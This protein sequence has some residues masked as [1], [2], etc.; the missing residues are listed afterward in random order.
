MSWRLSAWRRISA[1]D[2]ALRLSACRNESQGMQIAV[3]RL[4]ERGVFAPRP[5]V[6]SR[7]ELR[8]FSGQ[9]DILGEGL[10]G[11]D[12]QRRVEHRTI[13]SRGGK[14]HRSRLQAR[15]HVRSAR[16]R[17]DGAA[18]LGRDGSAVE[19]EHAAIRVFLDGPGN[20]AEELV[21]SDRLDIAVG[22]RGES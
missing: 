14:L 6:G 3:W 1:A 19:S 10:A 7:S 9:D 12:G 16:A 8:A 18:R 20:C 17:L 15:Q 5:V 22:G 4:T 11:Y 13:G 2:E 21:V